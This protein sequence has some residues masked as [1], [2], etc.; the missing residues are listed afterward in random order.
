[1]HTP[2][3]VFLTDIDMGN[4]A[5]SNNSTAVASKA[6]DYLSVND[7]NTDT[8]PNTITCYRDVQSL[9]DIDLLVNQ[10]V[11]MLGFGWHDEITSLQKLYEDNVIANYN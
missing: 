11:G 1:M 6:A 4:I 8:N 9:G 10:F 7:I 3:S 5:V 2:N